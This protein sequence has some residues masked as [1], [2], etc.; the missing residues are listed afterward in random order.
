M[1][2]IE[3]VEV[4]LGVILLVSPVVLVV[5][6]LVVLDKKLTLVQEQTP[7]LILERLISEMQ[8]VLVMTPLDMQV[9]EA[10]EA[11]VPVVQVQVDKVVKVD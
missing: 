7:I 1:L 6:L 9:A 8:E 10:V 4:V 5:V 2:P 3:V 11:A